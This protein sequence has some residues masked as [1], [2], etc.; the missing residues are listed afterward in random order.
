MSQRDL[1]AE[2]RAARVEAP[3][4]VRERVRLIAAAAPAPPRR[5]TWRRAAV[6]LVPAVA[7]IAAAVLVTRPSH[8]PESAIDA[9]RAR[10]AHSVT[11]ELAPRAQDTPSAA[12]GARPLTVP[13]AK[14]RAQQYD[15]SLALRFDNAEQVSDAVKRALRITSSVGGYSVSVHASTHGKR[16]VA[17]LRLKVP[18]SHVQGAMASLLQLG[19]LTGEDVSTVDKQAL[20]NATDREIA[21]LQKQLTDLRAQPPTP[22]LERRIAA[23]VA[24]VERLQ[25][26]EAATRRATHYA[27]IALHLAT[28]LV[29]IEHKH[30]HGPLHGVVV[31]L[32]WLGIG[33]VYAL[34]LGLPVALVLGILWLSLRGLRRRRVDALLTRS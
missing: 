22:Q 15:A 13:S 4:E 9:A 7:A 25:R 31:A 24:R 34:A 10:V 32:K 8:H 33:A 29:V 6:V 21:R 2:L 20:L 1:V 5:V 30:G 27:T 11:T 26:G 17:D 19:T 3:P 18:R 12:T 16:A 28:A 14:G 23:L